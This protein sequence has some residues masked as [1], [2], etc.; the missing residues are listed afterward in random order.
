MAGAAHRVE[1]CESP[2]SQTTACRCRSVRGPFGRMRCRP[3]PRSIASILDRNCLGISSVFSAT[4]QFRNQGWSREFHRLGFI[5]RRHCRHFPKPAQ[6][7]DRGRQVGGAITEVRAQRKIDHFLHAR[8]LDQ[9]RHRK[10]DPRQ[11]RYITPRKNRH[12]QFSYNFSN[13]DVDYLLRS[14]CPGFVYPGP[15]FELGF[16]YEPTFFDKSNGQWNGW[17]S[18]VIGLIADSYFDISIF[19]QDLPERGCLAT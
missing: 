9:S 4:A 5:E 1:A 7:L 10:R 16:G 8:I 13:I 15:G 19:S 3:M 18:S 2:H 6:F 11:Q 14:L 17:L 12:R